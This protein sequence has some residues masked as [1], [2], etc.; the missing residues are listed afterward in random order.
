MKKQVKIREELIYYIFGLWYITAFLSGANIEG[1][2]GLDIEIITSVAKT[3]ILCGLVAQ[4]FF[5]QVYTRQEMFVIVAMSVLLAIVTYNSS[6]NY[7]ATCWI[8]IFASK[9]L[10]MDRLVR[11]TY[12]LSIIMIVFVVFLFMIGSIHETVIIRNGIIRHSLGFSHPNYLGMQLFHISACRYYM[13][14]KKQRISDYL[15]AIMAALIAYYYPNT[16]TATISICVVTV[17]FFIYHVVG[18]N[19]RSLTL[20]SV[21]MVCISIFCNLLSIRLSV[22]PIGHREIIAMIDSILSQRFTQCHRTL[23]YYGVTLFGQRISTFISLGSGRY[24]RLFLDNGYMAILMRYGIIMYVVF[25]ITLFF[26]MVYLTRRKQ[27]CV[28]MVL[29][30]YSIYGLMENNLFSLAHNCFIL[31]LGYYV[32]RKKDEKEYKPAK[33]L[34]IVFG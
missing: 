31:L 7:M 9:N 32:F 30:C 34:R 20:F 14:Y 6:Y 5:F 27:Y 13:H 4:L 19:D 11:I 29:A 23:E 26:T 33:R 21:I 17:F 24:V 18:R 2:L 12:Y 25:S 10:E 8:F 28:V 1:L 3:V 16:Y 15:F 22:F